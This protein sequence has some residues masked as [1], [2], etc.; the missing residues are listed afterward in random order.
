MPEHEKSPFDK[1]ASKEPRHAPDRDERLLSEML[2]KYGSYLFSED[3]PPLSR[4]M[5]S[6]QVGQAIAKTRRLRPQR[7]AV[8]PMGRILDYLTAHPVGLAVAASVCILLGVV[9]IRNMP[10]LIDDVGVQMVALD[11][12]A[13]R[14][15]TVG[16]VL[17]S[18]LPPPLVFRDPVTAWPEGRTLFDP[19]SP[20]VAYLF[21]Y[22]ATVTVERRP[23]PILNIVT[24]CFV[25]M[26]GDILE[27]LDR[28][29]A[30]I[31]LPEGLFKLNEPGAYRIASDTK[32]VR[33]S[34]GTEIPKMAVDMHSMIISPDVLLGQV[35]LR[36][37][38]MEPIPVGP[39]ML[40]SPWGHVLSTAPDIIWS[41]NEIDV[42][43]LE[44]VP[45]ADLP[46]DAEVENGKG[47]TALSRLR[48]QNVQGGR[49]SWSVTGWP[50]L[51]RDSAWRVTLSRDHQEVASSTFR[52]LPE[53]KAIDLQGQ[54]QRLEDLLPE[55][56]ALTFAQA[57][58]L[59]NHRPSCA[60]EARELTMALLRSPQSGDNLAYWKLLEHIYAVMSLPEGLRQVQNE[61]DSRIEKAH[62]LQTE[63]ESH[64]ELNGETIP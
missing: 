15:N 14:E 33:V 24:G 40:L 50:A 25:L 53:Q 28:P 42:F 43:T 11:M 21:R 29:P 54:L 9:L 64:H 18:V 22:D 19:E 8:R 61:I 17:P 35:E 27:L 34:D 48:P 57:S 32:L 10:V 1:N 16:L 12:S 55:G 6:R 58:A 49:V 2:D 36:D 39:V 13:F 4:D 56:P 62:Q 52:I 51:P 30:I 45:I 26:P 44:A 20:P 38:D 63:M 5:L 47:I 37:P 59:L 60:A 31:L 7:K 46:H 23:L 3:P 41:G